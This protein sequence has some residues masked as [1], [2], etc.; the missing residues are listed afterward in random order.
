MDSK[1]PRHLHMQ[2]HLKLLIWKSYLQRQRRWPILVIET[3]FAG[4]FFI[5]SVFIAKPV[6]LTPITDAPGPP[7]TGDAILASLQN[8]TILGYA[9]NTNPY[10][11]VM[12]KAAALLKINVLAGSSEND[13]NNLLY[14]RSQGSPLNNS[15][16]WVIWKTSDNNIW[17]FSIKSSE[18][19]RLE[20]QSDGKLSPEQHLSTGFLAVQLAVS[21]AILEHASTTSPKFELSLVAMPVSPL[22]L[23]PA[24]KRALAGILLCFTIALLPTVLEIEALVVSE[25]VSQFKRALRIRDVSFSSIYVGWL[26]YAYLTAVPICLL[27]SITLIIIFRWIHLLFAFI[28]VLAYKTVLIMLALIMAMFHNKAWIACTW[29]TLFTLMQTFISELLVH[30][31]FDIENKALTFV[32]Q[33]I[34]PPLGLVHAF[35]EF[36]LLQT[37]REFDNVVSLV[38]PILS[39][40]LMIA[41]YFFLLMMLQRTISFEKAIGGQVPWKTVIFKKSTDINKLHR[42][43]SLTGTERDNLQAV[44]ELVAKAISFRNVSKSMMGSVVLSNVTFDVYRGEFSMIIADRI[45]H[46]MIVTLTDLFT[47]LTF[48]DKGT[49]NVLGHELRPGSNF[50]N[51]PYMTGF[52]HRN[53]F[54]IQ[55]LTVEEHLILFLEICLWHETNENIIEYSQVRIRQL[56]K[57]GDLEEVKDKQIK[58][59]DV[60]YQAQLCWAIALLLEPRII[61]LDNFTMTPVYDALI[62]DKIMRYKKYMTIVKFSFTSI[63]ME[64]ADRV[65]L[66]DD[67]TLIF[68]G[69]PAYMFFKYGREYR[70]RLTFEAG[71]LENEAMPEILRRAQGA[72]ARVRAN[73]G[74]LLIL[75]VPAFPTASVAA[76]IKELTIHTKDYGI[77]SMHVSVPDS[78]E[79]CHRQVTSTDTNSTDAEIDFIEYTALAE[80]ET[81]YLVTRAIDSP[82]HYVTLYA[83]GIE[84]YDMNNTLKVR[85]LHSPPHQDSWTAPRS[86]ARTF[87]ALLRHYTGKTDATIQVTDD[88]LGLDLARWLTYAGQGPLLE[89]FLLTLT[90]L[91]ITYI[92]SKEHGL[93]RHMQRNAVSFNNASNDDVISST[94]RMESL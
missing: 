75:M 78:Q 74:S 88:P 31:R 51:V 13:L 24:V 68:G 27:A 43:E 62:K 19:A 83:Y 57:E 10:D 28:I 5:S 56:L 72:G 60:Y 54:L 16:I 91:H 7:L 94:K 76:F 33:V 66:F 6:F 21:Q 45:H 89:Q 23:Q 3:L 58:Y 25:S 32:L 26:M 84:I 14:N 37:G 34:L 49:I 55:D 69:T 82:Q 20:I 79:V 70:L 50:M 35:N 67:K 46:K 93:I 41:F 38:Y 44:D 73:L 2:R 90:N 8:D 86:F 87:M 36:A 39:W 61:I 15:V 4:V 1:K 17:K 29:T 64:F 85:V 40:L 18:R 63:K 59:L 11:Q 81:E 65:F 9:P 92:P 30:H 52:C 80:K 47:G 71:L 12:T 42:I 48:A 77:T 22:M 53:H